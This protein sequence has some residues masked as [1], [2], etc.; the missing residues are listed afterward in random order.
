MAMIGHDH[1]AKQCK[2]IKFLHT[3]KILDSLPSVRCIFEDWI[4]IVSIGG[5]EHYLLVLDGM[6]MGHR[7]K[8]GSTAQSA[9][10]WARFYAK[11]TRDRSYGG[12]F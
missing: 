11:I 8:N 3:V 9:P 12:L 10:P 1:E 5:D 6:A 2:R 4:A 7:M